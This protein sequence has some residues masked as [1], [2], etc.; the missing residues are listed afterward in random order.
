MPLVWGVFRA[1]SSILKPIRLAKANALSTLC[2]FP[3]EPIV[4]SADML[5]VS[6][7]GGIPPSLWAVWKAHPMKS[8]VV[9]VFERM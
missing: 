4:T 1:Q 5:S 9:S 6:H 3:S 7:T 8:S 2:L